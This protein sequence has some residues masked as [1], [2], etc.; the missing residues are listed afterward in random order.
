MGKQTTWTI[1]RHLTVLRDRIVSKKMLEHHVQKV[2]DWIANPLAPQAHS[3]EG[4]YP[5]AVGVYLAGV[6]RL[7]AASGCEQVL[8]G[9][10]H[11]W[12]DIAKSLPVLYW[13]RRMELRLAHARCARKKDKQLLADRLAFSIAFG[14]TFALGYDEGAMWLGQR[15]LD[16]V[17]S[18]ASFKNSWDWSPLSPFVY[19]IA[20]K[21][22][23]RKVDHKKIKSARDCTAY[24][25]IWENWRDPEKL[26]AACD[27]AAEYHIANGDTARER[28]QMD[29][30]VS[31]CEPIP[32]E[33]LAILRLRREE[34]LADP[35]LTHPFLR[36]GLMSPPPLKFPADKLLEQAIKAGKVIFP[37]L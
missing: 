9:D 14:V 2:R 22:L 34:K 13:V 23:K 33:I 35:P 16:D 6:G 24:E 10:S 4:A 25:A 20:A 8:S 17:D 27:A 12:E 15:L 26:G 31:Q 7:T 32:W 1:K 21:W 11:G 3:L 36:T 18:G 30:I 37:D 29:F 28:D 5:G 19:R